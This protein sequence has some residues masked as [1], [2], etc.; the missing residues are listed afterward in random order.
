M[1]AATLE[2]EADPTH[3]GVYRA[4]T[5]PLK[6]GEWQIAVAESASAVRSDLRLT[7]RVADTGNQELS[8]LTMN[9]PL[10]ETMARN[11]NGR[12]LREEQ[13]GDL[14]NLLQALDRKQTVTRETILWSSWWWLGAVIALLTAEWILRRRLRMV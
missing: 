4:R 5:P 6:A 9:R 7:L 12:F 8:S 13:A 1:D 2:L 10:L 14:P 11:A 3:A